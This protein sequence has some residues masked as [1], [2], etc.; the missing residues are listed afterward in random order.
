MPVVF[1]PVVS[2]TLVVDDRPADAAVMGSIVG[3]EVE[4]HVAVASILRLR[5]AIGL[6]DDGTRWRVVDDG[7]FSRLTSVRL[8]LTVGAGVPVV[9]FDGHVAR[10]ETTWSDPATGSSWMDVIAMDATSVMNLEEVARDWPNMTDSLIAMQI[11]GEHGL[12]PVVDPTAPPRLDT[13]ATVIQRD[14]DI[15]FLRQL[16]ERNGFELYVQPGPVPGVVEGHFHPPRLDLPPQGVVTVAIPGAANADQLVVRNDLLRPAQVTAG[17]IDAGTVEAQAGDTSATSL[18]ELGGRPLLG[19]S[20]PRT[21]RLRPDGLSRTGELQ[22]AAQGLVD[23]STWAVTATCRVDGHAYG[24]VVRP[25]ATVL[26]RGAGHA[27]SGTYYVESVRHAFEGEH[28]TSYHQYLTLRR[29]AL[30]PRGTEVY[31]SSAGL[32]A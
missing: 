22:A 12:V 10:T 15:R 18:T 21:A 7:A 17:G 30:E 5:L 26:L 19:G 29:N 8:L 23:R 28:R 3:L 20:R 32:P 31:L 25:G 11:F 4:C 6:S 1:S 27:N 16:A 2:Y 24:G 9:V 14:T 13:D